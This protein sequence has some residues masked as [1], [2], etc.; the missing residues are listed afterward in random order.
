MA[1]TPAPD[2]RERILDAVTPL[3]YERGARAV[4]MSEVVAAAGCGR[5]LL[6]G[7]FPSKDDLVAAYLDRF[8]A[9][10]DQAAADALRRAGDDP[11]AQ[12]VALVE[13]VADRIREP[14]FRGCPFRNHLTDCTD[15]ESA[16]ARVARDHLAESRARIDRLVEALGV[17]DPV[18]LADRVWLVLDG[19]YAEAARREGARTG[20]TAV[21]LVRESIERASTDR[22]G[23]PEE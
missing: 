1:R 3:F 9:A 23:L 21:A 20:T 11:A 4:G 18:G 2:T 19:L 8:R 15:H 22:H 7:Q 12:L 16:P 14:Y 6:Y 17:T 13:E 5:N 10:R